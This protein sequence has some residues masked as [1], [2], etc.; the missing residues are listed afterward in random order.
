MKTEWLYIVTFEG[1]SKKQGTYL[2][3]AYGSATFTCP[4]KFFDRAAIK[5]AKDFLRRENKCDAIVIVNI[6]KLRRCRPQKRSRSRYS[7]TQ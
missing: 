1:F 5:N 7:E 4:K 3:T 2:R 6:K